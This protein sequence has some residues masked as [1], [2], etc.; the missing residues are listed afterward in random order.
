M[1]PPKCKKLCEI[2]SNCHHSGEDKMHNC[3]FGPCPRCK[4]KC[5]KDLPCGH[6]CNAECHENVKV[7][8]EDK[9]RPVGPWEAKGPQFAIV[10]QPCP[11][12]EYPVSVTCLGGHDTSMYPCHM[13]KPASCGRK[14]GRQLPCGNHT[15][16]RDCHKVR[17]AEDELSAGT[18][19]KKCDLECSKPRPKG[20]IHPCS[21]MMCHPGDCPE[22]VVIVKMKCH[23]GLANIFAKC[24]EYLASSKDELEVLLCCKDQ[25]P[26]LMECGHRCSRTCHT[27]K[28]SSPSDC[29]KKVKITCK[30]KRKKEEFRCNQVYNKKEN[31]VL[32]DESCSSAIQT[33]KENKLSTKET[34][35]DIR[36]RKEAELFERQMQGG[37]KK[38]K[39]RNESCQEEKAGFL[40]SNALLLGSVFVAV[41]S[42]FVFAAFTY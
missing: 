6:T 5:G 14:C 38:R 20:C 8:V 7:K 42:V 23:C 19:C 33:Q 10:S 31:L 21:I 32:C 40:K 27:G 24:G 3:H 28:C 18:N 26:K 2:P 13:A 11:P 4:L 9:S 1:K 36:N 16:A 37:K 15:C 22:C 41:M 30:C 25:C 17:G 12:C 34:E 39:S 35:E 29:K